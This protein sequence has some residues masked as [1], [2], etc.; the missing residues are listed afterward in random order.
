[1]KNK[2]KAKQRLTIKVIRNKEVK[3]EYSNDTNSK[4]KIC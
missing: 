2:I 3:N 1:M 4:R